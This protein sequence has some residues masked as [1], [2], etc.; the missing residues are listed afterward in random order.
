MSNP[1]TPGGGGGP[2]LPWEEDSSSGQSFGATGVFGTVEVPEEPKELPAAPAPFQASAPV[3]GAH[4]FAE[5]V[6]HKVSFGGG[7]D[8]SPTQLIDKIRMVSAER[9]A[10]AEKPAAAGPG[11]QTGGQG[12]SG[13]TELLRTLGSDASAV[14]PAARATPAP[15][16]RPAAP[17]S[18]F[19][20]LLQT[21]NAAQ[22]PTA[23][24]P[25]PTIPARAIQPEAPPVPVE[26]PRAAPASGGGGFTELLRATDLAGPDQVIPHA[27]PA[28]SWGAPLGGATTPVEEKKPGAF[29]Q[30]FQNLGSAD[31]SPAVNSSAP[32]PTES[33]PGA[34]TQMFASLGNA[35][36]SPAMSSS[37]PRPAEGEPGSFTQLFGGVGSAESIAPAQAPIETRESSGSGPGSFTRML[38][39]EPPSVPSAATYREEP[40]P[41]PGRMDY[42]QTPSKP[43]AN[44]AGPAGQLSGDPFARE[45]PESLPPMESAPATGSVGITRLLQILD[46]P[47]Q[48]TAPMTP[49]PPAAPPAAAGPGLWTQT[50]EALAKPGAAAAAPPAAPSWAPPAAPAPPP[51]SQFAPQA[52]PA[53]SA[54]SGP[55]E[56]TRILDASKLREMAMRGGANAAE[57]A[58]AAPRQAG[59]GAP[60][61]P[62]FP[63][64]APSVQVSGPQVS[65]F[66]AQPPS[67]SASPPQMNAPQV[68]GMYMPQMPPAPAPQPPAV[69]PPEAPPNK[70]QAFVPLLLV[71]IIVLLVVILVVVIFLMKH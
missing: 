35:E 52:A 17:V 42:A 48:A 47:A 44:A 69:K 6:V 61:I 65:G 53:A 62:G 23:P 21:L 11:S 37:A 56:F 1:N 26:P 45:V 30:M 5:P 15:E 54:A 13:F 43:D 39:I 67:I 33:K 58:A 20:S 49:S 16:M 38:S 31:A 60:G 28:S 59:P 66:S 40:P 34:F 68:P 36:T 14:A 27:P 51:V 12:S 29:T 71:A 55:S 7:A 10:F 57:S 64:S 2:K 8:E 3:P 46:E 32:I 25:I 19:T 4:A 41:L 70:L 18:G 9:Q 22:T 63:V 50:F 24:M